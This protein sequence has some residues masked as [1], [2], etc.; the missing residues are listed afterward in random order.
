MLQKIKMKILNLYSGVGGNR[1]LWGS[2][3]ITAVERNKRIAGV[4]RLNFSG[5]TIII[6]DAQD[7]LLE[8]NGRF[9][10]T[11]SSPPCQSHTVM[12]KTT[13]HR[14]RRMPDM[15]LYQQIIFFQHFGKGL[16]V[17][18][19]VMPFYKPLIAPTAVLGRHLFWA[20][21]EIP[22]I[23]FR[24]GLKGFMGK[25]SSKDADDL[26]RKIGIQYPGN[27][28]YENGHSPTQVLRNCV[29]PKLGLY[30]LRCAEQAAGKENTQR[31]GVN[32]I[33]PQLSFL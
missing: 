6:A 3:D 5:D 2:G 12:V 21:F 10:F 26:K 29:D 11:W 20:N 31:T 30:V 8:N 18:E 9:E 28:Y 4:Y 24:S 13:R 14:V 17:V 16:W 23:N 25:N 22:H 7:Y 33:N 32:W 1:L 19:N 27:V 15:S